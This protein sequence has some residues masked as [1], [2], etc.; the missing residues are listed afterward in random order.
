MTKD[1]LKFQTCTLH[2]YQKC[3]V[4]E[5]EYEGQEVDCSNAVNEIFRLTSLATGPDAPKTLSVKFICDGMEPIEAELFR[6]RLYA[7]VALYERV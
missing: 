3:V 4:L 5:G 1:E 7:Q 6:K 2:R